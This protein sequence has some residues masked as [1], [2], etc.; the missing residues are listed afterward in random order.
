MKAAAGLLRALGSL[1]HAET[2][3]SRTAEAL[4]VVVAAGMC[5]DE[6]PALS[7][8]TSPELSKTRA[9]QARAR[10]LCQTQHFH[11]SSW[12]DVPAPCPAPKPLPSKTCIDS[13]NEQHSHKLSVLWEGREKQLTTGLIT[14]SSVPP[15][16]FHNTSINL[17]TGELTPCKPSASPR[18]REKKQGEIIPGEEAE[19]PVLTAQLPGA[20]LGRMLRYC[21]RWLRASALLI[22]VQTRPTWPRQVCQSWRPGG[23]GRRLCQSLA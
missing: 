13:A 8:H 9:F 11:P 4:E 20:G 3:S 23:K 5:R 10:A 21:R 7:T 14:H 17:P 19:W 6:Q 15:S 2:F 1:R 22:C 12:G 16:S 18:Q